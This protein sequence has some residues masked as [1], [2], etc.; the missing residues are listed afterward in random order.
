MQNI[1]NKIK[2]MDKKIVKLVD[3][4]LWISF[5]VSTMGVILLMIHYKLYISAEFYYIGI[6][7]FKLGIIGA[8]SIIVCSCGLWI[9]KN[10]FMK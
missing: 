7:V 6:E 3:I 9:V 8:V 10:E 4:G 1:I 2:N 5:L